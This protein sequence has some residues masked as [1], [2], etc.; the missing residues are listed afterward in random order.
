MDKITFPANKFEQF[1]VESVKNYDD[2]TLVYVDGDDI[3]TAIASKEFVKINS[4]KLVLLG[5]KKTIEDNLIQIGLNS[6]NLEIV[7]P[8]KSEKFD[9]YQELLQKR[10][11]ERGKEITE[12]QV[13]DMVSKPN[14]Y[15]SIML[16]SGDA[17]GGVSGSLSST[18]TMMRPLIQV[19]GTG[20]P[21]R[22]LSGAA[23]EIIPESPY[24]L[25]GQFLFADT[26]VIPDPDEVQMTDIVLFSYQ[27]ARAL[28]KGEPKIA[29]LSYSTKGSASGEKIDQ[30]N[31]VIKRVR[32]IEPRIKIDGELQFDAAV[33]P[34]VARSKGVDSEVAGQANVLIFPNLD[35]TNICIKAVHRLAGSFYYGSIIQGSPVPFNDL[36]RGCAPVEVL[37]M[38]LITLM[39]VKEME[40]N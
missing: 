12:E 40:N 29:M 26:A 7:E 18:Q 34:E 2:K 22:Y 3:R 23:I 8:S 1:M 27:T 19:M 28:F 32:E 15:A 5:N 24:G 35:A 37:S 16:K 17:H 4:S 39:Q 33:V 36:S 13:Q 20:N 6:D 25:D 30:I 31:R 10:F 9:Y 11:T 14:Y 38:S 21:K